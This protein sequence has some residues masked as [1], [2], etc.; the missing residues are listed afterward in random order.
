VLW[1]GLSAAFVVPPAAAE[2]LLGET[3]SDGCRVR[4]HA[5]AGGLNTGVGGKEAP[6]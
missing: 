3:P 1:R 2:G 6:V 5:L 4:T